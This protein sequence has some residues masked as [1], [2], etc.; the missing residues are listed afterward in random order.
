MS[1]HRWKVFIRLCWCSWGYSSE[2][3]HLAADQEVPGSGTGTKAV[4][5]GTKVDQCNRIE[6]P[7]T[8]SGV[9][10]QLLYNKEGKSIQW[11]KDSLFN[12]WCWENW[13][14]TWR[15][16]KLEHSLTLGTKI[17]YKWIKDLNAKPNTIKLLKENIQNTPWHKLQTYCFGLVS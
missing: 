4:N 16:I 15:R 5:K 17:N 10:S 7:E 14:A 2:L 8:N 3:E 9:Y 13:T 1:P 12:K 6:S 11:G